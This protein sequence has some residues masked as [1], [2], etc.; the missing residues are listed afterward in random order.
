MRA[1]EGEGEP[2]PVVF[3]QLEELGAKPRRG[4]VTLIAAGPGGGKSA[5]TSEWVIE[6]FD[7][8]KGQKLSGMYFSADTDR[9][10]LGKR[11]AAGIIGCNLN[12]AEEWLKDDQ[13]GIWEALEE[14]TSHIWTC[15][16]ASLTLDD[17]EAEVKAYAFVTGQ[18]PDFVVVDVLMNVSGDN[19]DGDHVA[20][21]EAMKYFHGMSRET[22]SAFFVL[23]HVTGPYENGAEP[24]PLG[25][26]LGKV[27]KLAR[28]VLTLHRMDDG[29][30]GVSVVKNSSGPADTSGWKVRAKIPWDPSRSWFGRTKADISAMSTTKAIDVINDIEPE[31]EQV[32]QWHEWSRYGA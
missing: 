12:E 1:T 8:T 4:Q 14:A 26:I 10:T 9:M 15:F 23:H 19:S 31:D 29:I 21:A 17:I 2:L 5:M 32:A 3:P 28:L 16:D 24:I 13:F 22:N 11:A 25:G 30:L 6:L 27:T 18:W 20:F 7:Q